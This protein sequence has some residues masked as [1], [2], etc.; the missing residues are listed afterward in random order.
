M[1]SCV[2]PLWRQNA[3]TIDAAIQ[4]K[5]L[6]VTSD[7]V[8]VTSDPAFAH[9]CLFLQPKS[10]VSCGACATQHPSIGS[11]LEAIGS[12]HNWDYVAWQPPKYRDANSSCARR[13]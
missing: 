12:R 8:N 4:C 6:I 10:D 5:A 2:L 13:Q 1:L 7:S 9:Y 3:G 11:K